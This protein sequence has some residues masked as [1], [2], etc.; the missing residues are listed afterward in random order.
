[1]SDQRPEM[2]RL[3]RPLPQ[4]EGR[5]EICPPLP[6]SDGRFFMSEVMDWFDFM[7]RAQRLN[8]AVG[9][10]FRDRLTS[11]SPQDAQRAQACIR[12][13]T[14]LVGILRIRNPYLVPVQQRCKDL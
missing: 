12:E 13:I 1:M 14:D 6:D 4:P 8:S 10:F 3:A 7:D 2:F 11:M 9:D 5:R